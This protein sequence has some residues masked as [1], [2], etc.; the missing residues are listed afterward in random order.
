MKFKLD[1]NLPLA[2]A[3]VCP[4]EERILVTLDLDFDDIRVYSPKSYSGIIVLRLQRQD[5]GNVL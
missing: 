2:A 1:E 4:D 3:D 5:A